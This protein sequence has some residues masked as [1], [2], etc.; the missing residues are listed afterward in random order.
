MLL[1]PVSLWFHAHYAFWKAE[2]R[3][4]RWRVSLAFRFERDRTLE[5][6]VFERAS[7]TPSQNRSRPRPSQADFPLIP[8]SN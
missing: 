5:Q 1:L 8:L 7:S 4:Y 6:G 3:R 2:F